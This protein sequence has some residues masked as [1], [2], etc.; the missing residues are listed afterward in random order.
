MEDKHVHYEMKRADRESP[1]AHLF[2]GVE[3]TFQQRFAQSVFRYEDIL[4]LDCWWFKCCEKKFS[5]NAQ[6]VV[7]TTLNQDETLLLHIAL[8]IL[9]LAICERDFNVVDLTAV[10]LVRDNNKSKL[11]YF[12][13]V[14]HFLFVRFLRSIIDDPFPL[15]A[16]CN[17]VIPYPNSRI[18][19]WRVKEI[20]VSA[21]EK[22][23]E[24]R[25]KGEKGEVKVRV[26]IHEIFTITRWAQRKLWSVQIREWTEWRSTTIIDFV[27]R[28][29]QEEQ[30]NV[31]ANSAATKDDE[32]RKP[33]V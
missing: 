28:H 7:S 31:A 16:W 27:A 32:E 3:S 17:Y 22:N 33:V 9:S 29:Q 13:L 2:L 23:K 30:S 20:K 21:E 26:D 24:W 25:W 1:R 14:I 18:G 19:K 15:R 8:S 12:L 11:M 5:E 4:C 6:K 10:F